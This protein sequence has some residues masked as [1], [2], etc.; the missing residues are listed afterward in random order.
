[1]NA[2]KHRCTHSHT[3]ARTHACTYVAIQPCTTS[4]P[5][6][7]PLV[8]DIS[9]DADS[10]ALLCLQE[11][12]LLRKLQN[13]CGMERVWLCMRVCGWGWQVRMGI[14]V[15]ARRQMGDVQHK[16][17]LAVDRLVGIY[18]AMCHD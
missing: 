14:S 8:S 5:F 17:Q 6:R 16:G 3:H 12:A 7:D 1:M 18:V 11:A 15:R 9:G 13:R 2:Q 10:V 4:L